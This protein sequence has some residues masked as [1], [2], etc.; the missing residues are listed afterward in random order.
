MN[1]LVQKF[2]GNSL[3]EPEQ[4]RQ[5][6]ELIE[7]RW[8][9]GDS[10]VV[11]VSA[12]GDTTDE[13]LAMA[14]GFGA[15]NARE[16]DQLLSTGET[17]SAAVMA[18]ALSAR[19]VPAVSLAGQQVGI[20]TVGAPGASTISGVDPE[21]I[22]SHL[23]QRSVVVVAG[24]Q[25][26]DGSGDL[27]TLG[28][29]GSDTTAVAL[30]VA[31]GAPVCEIYTDVNGVHTADPRVVANA[32]VL[33]SVP[34]E[35]MSEMAV[36]GAR[37]L[38]SRAVELAAAN[39]ITISVKNFSNSAPGT[40]VPG[41]RESILEDHGFIFAVTHLP[42]TPQIIVRGGEH[43][44]DLGEILLELLSER[45]VPVDFIAWSAGGAG[46]MSTG[47]TVHHDWLPAAE[48]V[49]SE[50]AGRLGIDY[51]VNTELATVSLVGTGLLNRP[52]HI[53]RM[54]R[55]LARLG[56]AAEGV[57]VTQSRASV[58]VAQ[59][60]VAQAT[61]AIHEEFGLDSTDSAMTSMAAT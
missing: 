33:P 54:L 36:S 57:T 28:R 37:V 22:L 3:A 7:R 16:L 29:G 14:G 60:R 5:V 51:W 44:K 41:R 38:H 45:F 52:G 4:V 17:A 53:S 23:Q 34:P 27:R 30:A 55:T 39:E 26:V 50:A 6:A 12:Q 43:G 25:G 31:L 58:L 32:A 49:L 42:H 19:G 35:V 56:I 24:F 2:G 20:S 59:K 61:A 47:V 46:E 40:I 9:D 11:V 48:K 13:L 10:P 21:R 15:D 8:A 18:L 1:V